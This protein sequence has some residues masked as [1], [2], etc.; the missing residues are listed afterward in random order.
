M[1]SP[2]FL[3]TSSF[4]SWQKTL[5]AL[6][7]AA[8]LAGIIGLQL[9]FSLPY[10]QALTPFNLL[11]SAGILFAFH[12]DWKPSFLLFCLLTFSIGFLVEVAGVAS[13]QIFGQYA[14]GPTLGFKLWNVPL[15]IGL[16]WLMLI[17]STGMI[18]AGLRL[19]LVLKAALASCLMVL[20]DLLI[21]PV[22]IRLNF[23]T[24]ESPEIPLQNYLAWFT[25]S[26]CLHLLFFLLPF[27]K[28]NPAA[29]ILY[30]LQLVFFFIL[31]LFTIY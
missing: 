20:L 2:A 9:P 17:Y 18:C 21:E 15:V 24:W 27:R 3:S 29:K 22:A 25:V 16:N 19:P 26:F 31:F 6:L 10:F 14:Y 13:G 5:L 11:L 23:W 30:S 12:T 7:A 28:K 1:K 4:K 8:Y